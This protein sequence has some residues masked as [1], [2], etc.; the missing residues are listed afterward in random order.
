MSCRSNPILFT[1]LLER[2]KAGVPEDPEEMDLVPG[3]QHAG[4]GGGLSP[5][6]TLGPS[7]IPIPITITTP[8]AV[9]GSFG[10]AFAGSASMGGPLSAPEGGSMDGSA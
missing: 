1:E 3:P 7:P 10:A 5:N 2:A 8:V 4:A 6:P 9:V